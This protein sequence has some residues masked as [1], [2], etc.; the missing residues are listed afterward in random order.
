MPKAAPYARWLNTLN[1]L[2][3]QAN[4]AAFEGC[5][6]ILAYMNLKEEAK[7]PVKITD[8][9]QS[10]MFGTGP[11][12][13]RKVYPLVDRGL[14]ETTTNTEDACAKNLTLTKAGQNLLNERSKHMAQSL[15]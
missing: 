12:V 8:L 7:E 11:T 2:R 10:M 6:E 15:A 13:H 5:E 3:M 9:V 14:I 4:D 1:V